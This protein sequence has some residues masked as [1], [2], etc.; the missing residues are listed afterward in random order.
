MNAYQWEEA[1]R[2]EKFLRRMTDKQWWRENLISI[3]DHDIDFI[4]EMR[5]RFDWSNQYFALRDM[6]DEWGDEEQKFFKEFRKEI[7]ICEDNWGEF[8]HYQNEMDIW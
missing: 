6:F 5:D 8:H 4:R 7:A 2:N 1:K 3:A